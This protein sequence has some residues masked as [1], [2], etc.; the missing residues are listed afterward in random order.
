MN[1]NMD[2][3]A[4]ISGLFARL[5][6]TGGKPVI[7]GG[8][9][10]IRWP[11]G[12]LSA[13]ESIGLLSQ[14]SPATSIIC[15]DCE[16]QCVMPVITLPSEGSRPARTF[17]L[18]D[19]PSHTNRVTIDPK[20]LQQWKM[21]T[22][23][24]AH[25]VAHLLDIPTKPVSITQELWRLGQ[26]EFSDSFRDCFLSLTD[27]GDG[28]AS[29][30]EDSATFTLMMP[31]QT[32]K[33]TVH[34]T[35]ILMMTKNGWEINR[36][37]L[38]KMI[39]P[40]VQSNVQ[41][42]SDYFCRQ[43]KV[44]SISFEGEAFTLKDSVGLGYVQYLLR[45][46]NKQVSVREMIM[47]VNPPPPSAIQ[48]YGKQHSESALL[49]EGLHI[50][51]D[52]DEDVTSPASIA[53]YKKEVQRLKSEATFARESGDDETADRHEDE[54]DQYQTF[55]NANTKRGRRPQKTPTRS[56]KDTD[57]VRKR[58]TDAISKISEQHRTLGKHL[59]NA[60]QKGDP[61]CYLPE[62]TPEWSF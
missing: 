5:A 34:L 38:E 47:A 50:D 60:V 21:T 32:N 18:C 2:S 46:P 22:T 62:K 58:I 4:A 31:G 55:I 39:G 8:E 29:P 1:P 23:S 45:R 51:T 16:E 57:A 12:L 54:A 7:V 11:E 49:D 9:E 17:L 20:T 36:S 15:N 35:R 19:G 6:V 41:T 10:V 42:Q 27:A 25:A 61:C 56:T 44:C 33:G 48:S 37:R 13:F 26:A 59:Y 3:I 52:I 14:S 40:I 30:A 28:N 53:H 43:G 24:V